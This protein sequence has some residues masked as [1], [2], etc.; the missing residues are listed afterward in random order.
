MYVGG[1]VVAVEL[2]LSGYFR[3]LAS[4]SILVWIPKYRQR[5]KG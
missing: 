4:L 5:Y 1:A 3:R 2:L